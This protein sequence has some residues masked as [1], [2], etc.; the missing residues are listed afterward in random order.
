[1]D[2]VALGHVADAGAGLGRQYRA[3]VAEDAGRAARRLQEAQDHADGGGLA[4]AVAADEAEDAAPWHAEREAV[5]GALVAEEPGQPAG[6]DDGVG[7]G[8]FG[9]VRRG[10]AFSPAGLG[11]QSRSASLSSTALRMSSAVK[12]RKTASW[13]NASRAW[14]SRR[15]R[16]A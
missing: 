13:T 14:C 3:V 4:G 5:H 10:H 8:G 11:C 12:S 9:D 2:G 7:R 16:S 1:V 15:S 6:P